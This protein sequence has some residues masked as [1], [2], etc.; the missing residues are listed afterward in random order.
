MTSSSDKKYLAQ[1]EML[2]WRNCLP[3]QTTIVPSFNL[4]REFILRRG[5]STFKEFFLL[6][7]FLTKEHKILFFCKYY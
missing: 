1:Y 4:T 7:C 2:A 6:Q 5:D 3:Y